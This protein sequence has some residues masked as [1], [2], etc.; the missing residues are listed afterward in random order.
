MRY[1]TLIFSPSIVKNLIFYNKEEYRK[2]DILFRFYV[3]MF[4]F[5]KYLCNF[6]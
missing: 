3:L 1:V 2:D 6:A 5:R 4:P